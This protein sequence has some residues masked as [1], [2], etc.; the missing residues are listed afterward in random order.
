MSP[1]SRLDDGVDP[2]ELRFRTD[3]VPAGVWVTF[4]VCIAGFAYVVGWH[5]RHNTEIS[6]LVGVAA[7]GGG[8]I[9]ALPWERVVRSRYREVIFGAGSLLDLVLIIALAAYTGGGDSVF[10]ALPVIPIVFAGLSYPRS[11]V[12]A[13][14]AAAA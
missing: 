10:A 2:A 4:I 1:D 7:V 6:L 9:L 5:H 8:L 12:A 11:R 3:S 13:V 14:G